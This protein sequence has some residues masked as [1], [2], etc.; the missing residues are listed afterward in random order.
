MRKLCTLAFFL[1]LLIPGSEAQTKGS[2]CEKLVDQVLPLYQQ[3]KFR[4]IIPILETAMKVC[5]KD[6]GL[7]DFDYYSMLALLSISYYEQGV[8][9]SVMVTGE[10]ATAYFEKQKTA[11]PEIYYQ[12]TGRLG[13]MYSGYGEYD[14]AIAYLA[15]AVKH[16]ETLRGFSHE[17]VIAYALELA[18]CY[19]GIDDFE[20]SFALNRRIIGTLLNGGRGNTTQ[21]ISAITNLG[22]DFI[23]TGVYD[24]A[25]F[26]HRESLAMREKLMGRQHFEYGKGLAILAQAYES[27]GSYGD[28]IIYYEQAVEVYQAA[29]LSGSADFGTLLNNMAMCYRWLGNYKSAFD[30]VAAS[31]KIKR[32]IYGN[33]H[34]DVAAGVNNIG[35]ILE[36]MFDYRQAAEAYRHSLFIL[37]KLG[38]TGN[39]QYAGVLSNLG[40]CMT[41]LGKPD[42]ALLLLQQ[43]Y[44]LKSRLLG[45]GN[46]SLAV[47]LNN[48]AGVL[49]DMGRFEEAAKR[50][51]EAATLVEDVFGKGSHQLSDVYDNMAMMYRKQQKFAAADSLLRKSFQV[52]QQFLLG[53]TEGLTDKDK[54]KFAEQIRLNQYTALSLRSRDGGLSQSWLV[55]GTMFYKGLLLEGSKE[56]MRALAAIADTAVQSKSREYLRLKRYIGRQLLLASSGRDPQLDAAIS[57]VNAME[58]ELLQASAAFR[59]WKAQFSTGW[60]EIQQKL[61]PTEAA[62]EFVAAYQPGMRT[63]D[64]TLYFAMV[65]R[66]DREPVILPLFCE[67]VINRMIGKGRST[68]SVVQH[69]YR[70]T[71]RS[72]NGVETPSDSLYQV[73]WQPISSQ[74]RS[75]STVYFSVDG[76]LNN[77]NLAAMMTPDGN[78]LVEQIELVQLSSIRQ[79]L[80]TAKAPSFKMVQ[81][82]GGVQYGNI[83]ATASGRSGAFVYLPGT[84]E[85]VN[86]IQ[87]AAA[88]KGQVQSVVAESA[89]EAKFKQLSGQ[90]PEVLHIATH[91]FFFPDPEKTSEKQDGN[92]ANAGSPMLRSGIALAGANDHWQQSVVASD[93][94]DGILTAWEIA[95]MDLSGTKLVV[96][97][98]CETGLGDVKTGEGVYGLQRAFKLAGVPYLIMSLW[99]VPDRETREFMQIFYQHCFSGLSLRAAFR[100]TQLN[101]SRRYQ[102]YQWAAFVLLE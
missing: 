4:E 70:S 61:K 18:R 59:D 79:L 2:D 10:P 93:Q 91:G 39:L 84:L 9:D 14:N 1:C 100:Q 55:N 29:G 13:E 45:P 74:L 62:I 63:P 19:S 47:S 53:N 68:Q 15:Q 50:Y 73:I 42:S 99:Q 6:T 98:A 34:P 8:T 94:E 17:L 95:D 3:A 81:L 54:E 31:L 22:N 56:L 101:M 76:V 83:A 69:L 5:G 92:F 30:L 72:A 67:A 44:E 36:D 87:E 77:L 51:G 32:K 86:A 89:T 20:R 37:G 64:S 60:K 65:I 85:E 28:A 27:R 88:G 48:I 35:M 97:S 49:S 7:T 90:A 78:R 12:L 25:L 52:F 33:Y 23:R 24:S 66:A 26:Y 43:S 57:R 40:N 71:I 82:W 96:L 75:I 58:R 38:R 80:K 11:P 46:I 21:Y 41:E 16:Y 102:P